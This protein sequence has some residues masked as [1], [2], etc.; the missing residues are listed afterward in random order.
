MVGGVGIDGR[1]ITN[2]TGGDIPCISVFDA[3][4]RRVAMLLDEHCAAGVRVVTWRGTSESGA[5]LP[6]GVYLLRL[7][8][9][10]VADTAKL[11]LLR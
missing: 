4:G 6:S 7:E 10:T 11:V 1:T 2:L 8:S 9:E 5:P 3:A